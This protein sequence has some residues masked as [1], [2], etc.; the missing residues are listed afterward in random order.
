MEHIPNPFPLDSLAIS[1][2]SSLSK[3]LVG[4]TIHLW[5]FPNIDPYS[6]TNW[7][8]TLRSA[9]TWP[10]SRETGHTWKF[11]AGK[12]TYIYIYT[13][14]C[15]YIHTYIHTLYTYMIHTCTYAYSYIYIYI[16]IHTHIYIYI[17]IYRHIYIYI[18]LYT[19]TYIT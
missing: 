4:L 7:A 2:L 17:Y 10:A 11:I 12:I 5:P 1:I 8:F 18:Y 9:Q 19:H 15:T 6:A 14:T 3:K 16:C 13:Y